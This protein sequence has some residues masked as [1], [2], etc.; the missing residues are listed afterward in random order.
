MSNRINDGEGYLYCNVNNNP[1]EYCNY[2]DSA[3]EC[4]VDVR[5]LIREDAK[6]NEYS[7]RDIQK[8]IEHYEIRFRWSGCVWENIY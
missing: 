4:L 5:E 8:I 7:E 1:S 3:D 6:K 2:Y